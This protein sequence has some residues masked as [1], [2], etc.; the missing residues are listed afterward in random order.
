M[1]HDVFTVITAAGDSLPLFLGSGFGQPKNLVQWESEEVLARAVRSY[2]QGWARTTVA[3]NR[4]ECADWPTATFVQQSFPGVETVL[5]SPRVP[6]ALISALVAM[7]EFPDEAPL[8]VAAGDSQIKGG[9]SR[10]IDAFIQEQTDAATI[11]FRSQN[12]RWSYVLP[13]TAGEVRQVAEKRVIG[14]LATT[15]VF[16]FRRVEL[17]REAAEWC[18]VNSARDGGRFYVS[19]ALNFLI[20]RGLDVRFSEIPREVYRTWSLP[21]DFVRQSG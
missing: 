6:G 11:V 18:L 4:E 8:V 17:F 5:V 2:S 20:K 14:P 19:T 13:G 10:F 15:G 9:I 12:P 21:V 16:F 3:L 7:G 1:S